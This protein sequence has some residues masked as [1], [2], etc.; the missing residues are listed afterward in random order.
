MYD[1]RDRRIRFLK[2]HT[3]SGLSCDDAIIV[4]NENEDLHRLTFSDVSFSDYFLTEEQSDLSE[5][6]VNI[7]DII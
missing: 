6:E 7:Y 4:T 3:Y 2:G 1:P 5:H